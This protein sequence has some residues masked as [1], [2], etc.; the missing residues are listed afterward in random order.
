[1]SI[2]T[3]VLASPMMV[4]STPVLLLGLQ[5]YKCT[6]TSSSG[7]NV[8]LL[9]SSGIYVLLLF[10]SD[11]LVLLLLGRRMTRYNCLVDTQ[12]IALYINIA[13]ENH[14]SSLCQ[15]LEHVCQQM[16]INT[17]VYVRGSDTYVLLP[18]QGTTPCYDYLFEGSSGDTSTSPQ[19]YLCTTTTRQ[20][21]L[22]FLVH[23]YYPKGGSARPALGE[24][25]SE[26]YIKI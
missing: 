6:T 24:L 10:S 16:S 12:V 3:L 17:Y 4:D 11:T 18:P 14:Q 8:L 13:Y 15:G 19:W 25:A 20:T 22:Q 23:L 26:N 7:T 21:F 5:W 1:M 2:N 9:F